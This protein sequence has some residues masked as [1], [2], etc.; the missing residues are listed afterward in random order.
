MTRAERVAAAAG[1]TG[2]ATLRFD[3]PSGAVDVVV[4]FDQDEIGRRAD[5]GLEPVL[6]RNV[7]EFLRGLEVP[8]GLDDVDP[9]GLAAA[10]DGVGALVL[11]DGGVVERAYRPPLSVQA[12]LAVTSDGDAAIR[13]VGVFADDAPRIVGV[14]DADDDLVAEAHRFGIGVVLTGTSDVVVDPRPVEAVQDAVHWRLCERL[15]EAAIGAGVVPGS[16][17]KP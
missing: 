2:D 13:R 15:L 14:R 5:V 11:V 3:G 1:V 17:P 7:L 16:Q 8:T 12:V 10:A 4:V 6:D 9:V